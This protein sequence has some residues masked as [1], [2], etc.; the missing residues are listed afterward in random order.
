VYGT[1]RFGSVNG[2]ISMIV[3]S[4]GALAPVLVGLWLSVG[5]GG[6]GPVLAAFAVMSLVSMLLMVALGRSYRL[7]AGD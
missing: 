7:E 2:V 4:A 3:S 5:V 1:A 6:Y